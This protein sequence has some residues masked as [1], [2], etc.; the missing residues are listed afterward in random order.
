[1][2]F[3]YSSIR[4]FCISPF[5]FQNSLTTPFFT[6]LVLSRP[7]YN[8]TS[9][10]IGGPR[11]G[12]SPHLKFGEDRPPSPPRSPPLARTHTHTRTHTHRHTCVQ[13]RTHT[14]IHTHTHTHTHTC[15]QAR[16]HAAKAC[17]HRYW[18]YSYVQMHI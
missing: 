11:H 6:L 9:Q 1:M 14:H 4:F 10:N 2:T 16:T 3:F 8:T 7:S 5:L 13:S 17:T 18:P 15:K 12:P